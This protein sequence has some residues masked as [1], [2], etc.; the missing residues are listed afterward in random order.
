M[1]KWKKDIHHWLLCHM[2]FAPPSHVRRTIAQ[3]GTE[4]TTFHDIS[5]GAVTISTSLMMETYPFSYP[6]CYIY[7]NLPGPK[8]LSPGCPLTYAY[9][10]A[11]ALWN[12]VVRM[13]RCCLRYSARRRRLEAGGEE[14]VGE[15]EGDGEGEGEGEGEGNGDGEGVEGC[16]V[17]ECRHSARPVWTVC[18]ADTRKL[19]DCLPAEEWKERGAI[20]G[21]RI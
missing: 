18:D 17:G 13:C 7:T 4:S 11:E 16:E 6:R 2:K 5:I 3:Q 20:E 9:I 10:R 8:T 1:V 15:G 21:G 12:R 14:A 19:F